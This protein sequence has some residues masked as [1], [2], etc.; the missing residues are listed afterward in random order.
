[1]KRMIPNVHIDEPRDG[2][3]RKSGGNCRRGIRRTA[4]AGHAGV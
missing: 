2:V 1:M 3:P 4:G